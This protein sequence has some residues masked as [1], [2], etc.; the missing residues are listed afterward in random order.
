MKRRVLTALLT[1]SLTLTAVLAPSVA[2]ADDFDQKIEQKNQ[3]ITDLQNQQASLQSQINSLESEISSINSQAQELIVKQQELAEETAKLKEEIADLE[4]RIEKREEAIRNQA[5]D[6]QVN[7]GDA[8]IVEAVLNAE[9]VTDAIG[10]VQ[11]MTTIVN[12]NNDLVTQQKED[13][14]AVEDKKAETEAKAKE[15]EANQ[16][17]LEQK[18]GDLQNNQAELDSLKLDLA[19]QQASKEDEKSSLES[20]KAEAE[21]EAARQAEAV[22]ARQAAAAQQDAEEAAVVNTNSTNASNSGS[23]ASSQ[24]TGQATNNSNNSSTGGNTITTPDIVETPSVPAASSGSVVDIARQYLGIPYVWGGTTPS[25]FD[26]SGLVQYVYAQAGISLPRVTTEQEKCG[27]VIPVSE[28]QA[29]DLY[30]FGTRGAT[31]H[32]AIAIGGGQYIHAPQTGDVVKITS[33]SAYT[34]SFAVRL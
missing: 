34:P 3:E 24:G 33:V 19:I 12:A 14:Q 23:N 27:T 18:A 8:N 11:A 6:V 5:R 10:R 21:A 9:S 2:F 25:G 32:V 20:Q 16:L 28:A 22:A 29:G 31:H 26:C 17:E 30:F 15:I 7:G 1:C 4:V 13:K